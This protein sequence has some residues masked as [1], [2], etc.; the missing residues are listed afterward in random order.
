MSLGEN[1]SGLP[2]EVFC[3]S[4]ALS[5]VEPSASHTVPS[6]SAVWHHIRSR[7]DVEAR[8][9]H[10]I[11]GRAFIVLKDTHGMPADGGE[12]CSV[13]RHVQRL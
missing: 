8:K 11:A 6:V 12:V 2:Q 5:V 10:E 4:E 9:N 1:F 7:L 13:Q 3:K